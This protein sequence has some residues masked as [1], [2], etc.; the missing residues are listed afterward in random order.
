MCGDWDE[1]DEREVFFVAF[2]FL[3]FSSI[4]F[5]FFFLRC[6]DHFVVKKKND[7]WRRSRE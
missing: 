4:L 7:F 2:A 3:S 5:F 6:V 1:T